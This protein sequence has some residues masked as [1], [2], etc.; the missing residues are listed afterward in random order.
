[1]VK[2]FS[3]Q[4]DDI[5]A[6]YDKRL[7]AVARQS[8]QQ[9][10]NE[11]NTPKAKGGKMPVVFGFLRASG[12]MSLTGMPSGP[13]RPEK[14]QKY[15]YTDATVITSL[16]SLKIGGSIFYGWTAVYAR[17]QNVYNGFLDSAVQNWPRIVDG[18]VEEVKRRI[19]K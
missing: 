9:L 3:A 17:V 5:V 11:A 12:Q 2:K 8:T 6:M 10:V 7:T 16:A 1:M 19:A 13:T 14:D 18:V 15:E 4:V